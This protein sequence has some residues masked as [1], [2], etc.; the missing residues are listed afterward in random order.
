MERDLAVAALQ[1]HHSAGRLTFSEFEQRMCDALRART[2]A[3]LVPL[4]E[5]LPSIGSPS[6]RPP[7]TST[8]RRTRGR[9]GVFAGALLALSLA[10][11]GGMVVASRPSDVA[12]SSQTISYRWAPS[13]RVEASAPRVI[14]YRW[15]WTFQYLPGRADHQMRPAR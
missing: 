9:V 5:D 2:G 8:G 3:D 15:A 12:A 1:R 7:A 6:R 14:S 4:F 11:A 13:I 10:T